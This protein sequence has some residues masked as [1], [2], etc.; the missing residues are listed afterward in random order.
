MTTV[1]P[2]DVSAS[3]CH[4]NG[5]FMDGQGRWCVD[6]MDAP[7]DGLRSAGYAEL[8]VLQIILRAGT[9]DCAN[10]TAGARG[11][12]AVPRLLRDG[13]LRLSCDGYSAPQIAELLAQCLVSCDAC[14]SGAPPW[15]RHSSPR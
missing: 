10:M 11:P 1:H 9:G 12:F 5:E 8:E 4:D 13:R 3:A 15:R 2:K 14:P 6:Y 7:C